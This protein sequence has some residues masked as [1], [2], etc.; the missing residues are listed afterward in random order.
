MQTLEINGDKF[1]P[2]QLVEKMISSGMMPQLIKEI[3]IDRITA[4][5]SLTSEERQIA[6]QQAVQ[7]LGIDSEEKLQ[8]WLKR[9]GMSFSD[10]EKRSERA[11]KL[12]KYKQAI[13]GAKVNSIFLE[14]KPQLDRVVY[15]LICTKD[16]CVAQELYF[17]IKEGEQSF[18]ELAREYSQGPEAQTGGLIGPV[19]FGSI[20]ANLAKILLVSDAGQVQTPTV[21]GDWVVLVRLEKLLP[22]KL[23]ESVQ[24]RLIDE[25]FTKWLEESVSQ[26]VTSI[27]IMM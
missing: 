12:S 17:R 9:Q 15:S 1:Q 7:Q 3:T 6:I 26:Q 16:F 18:D 2:E 11:L 27:K 21:I 8:E 24:Q 19:E 5:I 4:D 23:D 13:W 22:V 14:R 20:N 25:S 10:L